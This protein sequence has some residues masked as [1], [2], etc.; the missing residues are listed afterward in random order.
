MFT[1][2]TT[3]G[4]TYT[5]LHQFTGS[6]SDGSTPYG[7]L[8]SINNN[9]YG[10]TWFG[11]AKNTGTLF[12]VTPIGVTSV[13]YSFGSSADGA[14]PYSGLTLGADGYYYGT[15]ASGGSNSIGTVFKFYP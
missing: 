12:S 14:N 15:T 8:V 7:N 4:G 13:V 2:P 5:V 3:V 9:I 11:G 6:T 1:L 10:T